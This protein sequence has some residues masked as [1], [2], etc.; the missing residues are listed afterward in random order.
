M[1]EPAYMSGF[2]SHF[3]TE[4]VPGALPEGRNSPQRPVPAPPPGARTPPRRP[5]FGFY[6][7]N[8]PAPAS[9]APRAENRRPWLSRMPPP[10]A[11]PPYRRYDGARLFARGTADA[12]LAPNRLRW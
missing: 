4:A 2:G 6:A 5:P 9:P 8:L 3:A 10:P 12:P 11:H 7:E 1:T